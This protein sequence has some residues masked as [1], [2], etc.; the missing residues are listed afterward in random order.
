MVNLVDTGT[1][2]R[3]LEKSW[4]TNI[5]HKPGLWKRK[6]TSTLRLHHLMV[7]GSASNISK[8]L[9]AWVPAP[10]PCWCAWF[11]AWLPLKNRTSKGKSEGDERG[12][13]TK[14][15]FQLVKR[16]WPV[17]RDI[18]LQKRCGNAPKKLAILKQLHTHLKQNTKKV[19]E[20][21][22]HAFP[23]HY[24]PALNLFWKSGEYAL[25][26]CERWTQ[27]RNQLGTPGGAKEFSERG[28]MFS[29]VSN[30]LK[31]C[32]THF[33]R[34]GEKNLMWSG[35]G[36]TQI[37]ISVIWKRHHVNCARARLKK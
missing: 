23:P 28:Q 36:P 17:A 1:C 22:S 4:S 20:R 5:Q 32:P 24:T 10:Q 6:P 11:V 9:N 25:C 26:W 33:C 15:S 7:S 8:L 13:A 18:V 27:A 2:A 35:Y 34:G 31:L 30:I 3:K 37:A 14:I 21:R 29:T 19:W 12:R 16:R